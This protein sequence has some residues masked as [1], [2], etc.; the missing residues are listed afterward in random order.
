MQKKIQIFNERKG[1]RGAGQGRGQ[2][3]GRGRRQEAGR[4]RGQ[5]AGRTQYRNDRSNF[6]QT[7][8]VS[9]K[10]GKLREII[11]SKKIGDDY[12]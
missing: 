10:V 6:Q 1:G 3:A 9:M 8:Q 12:I 11:I 7:L 2:E 5:E 4:G